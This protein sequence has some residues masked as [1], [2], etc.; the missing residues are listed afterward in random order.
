M[1]EYKQIKDLLHFFASTVV[2]DKDLKYNIFCDY[3]YSNN[4]LIFHKI[5][6]AEKWI[7]ENRENEIKVSFSVEGIERTSKHS[8][9]WE[10]LEE[11]KSAESSLEISRMESRLEILRAMAKSTPYEEEADTAI[12]MIYKLEEKL[13]NLNK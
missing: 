8:S 9:Y 10:E 3:Y 13:R 7:D 4:P 5:E 6:D 12:K 11:L 1:S 2:K